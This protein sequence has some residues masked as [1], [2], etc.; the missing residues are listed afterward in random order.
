[1]YWLQLDNPNY[2]PTHLPFFLHFLYFLGKHTQKELHSSSPLLL[3][4]SYVNIFPSWSVWR[5][6]ILIYTAKKK[7][8]YGRSGTYRHWCLSF[9]GMFCSDM[10]KSLCSSPCFLCWDWWTSF[11]L[12]HR[13]IFLPYLN[14]NLIQAC[15]SFLGSQMSCLLVLQV[16]YQVLCFTSEMISSLWIDK[17]FYRLHDWLPFFCFYFCCFFW[18]VHLFWFLS[19]FLGQSVHFRTMVKQLVGFI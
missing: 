6:R 1:M 2:N 8:N 7:K 12:W 15:F 18:G 5:S 11:R 17:L 10:E 13:F 4:I 9:Q 19:E 14:L 16:W 3:S